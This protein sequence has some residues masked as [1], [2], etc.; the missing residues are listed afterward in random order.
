M[1]Q[2]PKWTNALKTGLA[3]GLLAGPAYAVVVVLFGFSPDAT[4]VGYMPEQPV[5]YS[6][7]LHVGKLGLDC[8][9]CHTPVENAAHAAIPPTQ[10]CMNCHTQV[11]GKDDKQ[12]ARL[13]PLIDAHNSGTAMEWVRVHDIS[14][15]VYFNHAAHVNRG[16]SCVSCH[17]RVDHMEV[18]YQVKPLSMQWC[19]DCHRNPLPNLREPADVTK[20]DWKPDGDPIEYGRKIQAKYKINPSTDCSTCHR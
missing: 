12:Q 16:V 14:D 8:R 9:Y 18:V 7:L 10:T 11:T 13:K 15:F 3:L 20:L 6:H 19:L 5:P 1:F 4:D 17:G 2:F